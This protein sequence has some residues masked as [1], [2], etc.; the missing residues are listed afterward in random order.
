MG[1]AGVATLVFSSATSVYGDADRFAADGRNA[2]AARSAFT[3]ARSA[4]SRISCATCR[5][6]MRTGASPSCASSTRPERIGGACWA[7]RR[8]DARRTCFPSSAGS[9]RA[10]RASS[11]VHGDDWDTADGTGVRDY[12]HVQDLADGFVRALRYVLAKPG[13]LTVNL[14]SGRGHVG[15]ERDCSVRARVRALDPAYRG[16]A[17]AG[18]CGGQ[19]RRHCACGGAARL[20]SRRAISTRSAPMPGDGKRTAA[21]ID[22]PL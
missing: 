8:A 16:T 2:A 1:E 20:A 22:R 10:R 18:R 12:V 11:I 7:R 13:M 19:L 21:A 3:A 15:T 9:L 5:R 6:P 14:G 17:Q 4:S